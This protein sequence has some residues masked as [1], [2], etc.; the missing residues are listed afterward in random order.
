MVT[1]PKGSETKNDCAGEVGRNLLDW[2]ENTSPNS[3]GTD[4]VEKLLPT[5]TPVLRVTQPLPGNGSSVTSEFWLSAEMP[6]Y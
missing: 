6:Q 3:I 4:H 5:V 2:A 1:G